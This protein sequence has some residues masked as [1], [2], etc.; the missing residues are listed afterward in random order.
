MN[1]C[2]A[3]D[4]AQFRVVIA[5][6][7]A[8]S[9]CDDAAFFFSAVSDH[10][11]T[12][13]LRKNQRVICARADISPHAIGM[14]H[15]RDRVAEQHVFIANTVAT[16]NAA[17]RFLHLFQAAA[18]D[19]FE[20]FGIT[21][22][23]KSYD[24]QC[25]SRTT[26]HGV[27]IT[28]RIRC[29]DLSEQ[30]RI[31]HNRRKKVYGL[32]KSEICREFVNSSVVIRVEPDEDIRIGLSRELSQ[33]G[34]ERCGIELRGAAGCFRHCSELNGHRRRLS[35]PIG[36]PIVRDARDLRAVIRLERG[37]FKVHPPCCKPDVALLHVNVI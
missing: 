27:N 18:N 29:G 4:A 22:L 12:K 35:C 30:V 15:T 13:R 23:W 34:I 33:Y 32:H 16:D 14:N 11:S 1:S 7:A 20:N 8:K 25:R 36:R 2:S 9:D 5:C 3:C 28:E 10:S 6:T 37:I 31:V 26:A 21:V 19:R 24:R 17:L